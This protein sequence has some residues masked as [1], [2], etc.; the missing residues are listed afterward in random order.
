MHVPTIPYHFAFYEVS[1]I[2]IDKAFTLFTLY[3]WASLGQDQFGA[4]VQFHLKK[5]LAVGL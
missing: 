2:F 1:R 3:D 5:S 4:S